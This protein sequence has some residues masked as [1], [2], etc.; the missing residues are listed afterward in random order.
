MESRCGLVRERRGH[1]GRAATDGRLGH[2]STATEGDRARPTC[3][4]VSPKSGGSV[5]LPSMSSVLSEPGRRWRGDTNVLRW[6]LLFTRVF[7][8]G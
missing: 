4:F 3:W 1:G 7:N 6:P 8:V 5:P 2:S